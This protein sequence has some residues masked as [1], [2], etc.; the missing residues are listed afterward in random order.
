MGELQKAAADWKDKR[1]KRILLYLHGGLNS[2]EDVARRVV[3]FR[4]VFL[5]NEIYPLHIMWESG[6]MEALRDLVD[7]VLQK[8]GQRAAGQADWLRRFRDGLIEAK[9]LSL[10]F[11]VAGPGSL[12]WNEMKENAWLASNHFDGD[13]TMQE[14]TKHAAQVL[15]DLGADQGWEIHIVAHS[16][17]S[18]YIAYAMP[19]LLRLGVPIRTLQFLAPAL[20][21]DL[22]RN[23]LLPVVRAGKCPHPTVY[24]LSE[25]GER[26]DDV[27]PYGKSLLYLVSNSF[28]GKRGMPILGMERF[29]H[30][31][32]QNPSPDVDDEIDTFFREKVDGLPSLVIAGAPHDKDEASWSQSETHGGF[33][34]DV[35]TMNS[36]L[37]R[38]L[39][40]PTG[41][42]TRK[43]DLRDLQF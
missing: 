7:D 14:L 40:Q 38:I 1:T 12:L 26:D 41:D 4:D 23:A 18:I 31:D 21:V 20:R 22:F 35:A 37:R 8:P 42:L 15:S 30:R 17:G 11:T 25:S 6:F 3:A 39:N 29:I 10:E 32:E 19:L 2:E 34:N 43:F 28:E 36:V 9:D 24:I 33:D 13:G 5:A 27:G 16:A